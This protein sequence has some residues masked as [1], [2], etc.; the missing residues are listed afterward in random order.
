MLKIKWTDTISNIE[1]PVSI[2]TDKELSKVPV[3]RNVRTIEHNLKH[4]GT[5]LFM[6]KGMTEEKN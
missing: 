2:G 4:P 6:P 5:V 1:V 3:K